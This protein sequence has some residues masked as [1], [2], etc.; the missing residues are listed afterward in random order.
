MAESPKTEYNY[1]CN[2]CGA[3]FTAMEELTRHL[4][5]DHPESL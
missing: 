4:R 5:Q 2:D 1:T 3:S